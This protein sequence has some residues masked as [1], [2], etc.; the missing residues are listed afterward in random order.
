MRR[1]QFDE[2]RLSCLAPN[3]NSAEPL[4]QP[5]AYMALGFRT[6]SPPEKYL[7][8]NPSRR[9]ALSAWASGYGIG[10]TLFQGW[11]MV[12]DQILFWAEL[13]K[14][15]AAILAAERIEARLV[16]VKASAEAVTRWQSPPESTELAARW[17]LT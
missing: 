7:Q 2:S 5:K 10:M 11:Q 12:V 1:D 17:I 3:G 13:P 14:P 8:H 4:L 16:A 6:S 15:E 9:Q